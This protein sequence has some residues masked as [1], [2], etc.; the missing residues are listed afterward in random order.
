[1]MMEVKTN[2]HGNGSPLSLS[3]KS[4]GCDLRREPAVRTVLL[5]ASVPRHDGVYAVV[6]VLCGKWKIF[7]S[8]SMLM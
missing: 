4:P 2:L 1:M 6:G 7:S 5:E 3:F 8:H